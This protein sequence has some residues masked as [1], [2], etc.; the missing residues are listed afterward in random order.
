MHVRQVF[1]HEAPHSQSTYDD[2]GHEFAYILALLHCEPR[3]ACPLIVSISTFTGTHPTSYLA[4]GKWLDHQ[5]F[6]RSP[7]QELIH[8]PGCGLISLLRPACP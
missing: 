6:G 5:I 7:Q 8:F 1:P 2:Y 3:K 4:L